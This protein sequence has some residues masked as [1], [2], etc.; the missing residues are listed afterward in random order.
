MP[1]LDGVR[2]ER[3]GK[4]LISLI[5][6][7]CFPFAVVKRSCHSGF[8]KCEHECHHTNKGR[9]ICRCREGYTLESDGESCAGIIQQ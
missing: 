9:A 6:I 5:F 4:K 8:V 7:L 2:K 3:L 1:F